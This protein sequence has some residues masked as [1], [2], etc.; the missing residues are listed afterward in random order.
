[1]TTTSGV[2]AA[3]LASALVLAGCTT[4]ECYGRFGP[5]AGSL[6]DVT[7][8][9]GER[10]G[11]T[12]LEPVV[13]PLDYDEAGEE[14]VNLLIVKGKG[15]RHFVEYW[16]DKGCEPSPDAFRYEDTEASSSCFGNEVRSTVARAGV[17]VV[18]V[19]GFCVWQPNAIWIDDWRK[20]D[21]TVRLLAE[22]LVT[23]NLGDSFGVLVRGTP[24][25]SPA[26]CT[27]N[28]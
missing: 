9:P 28:D 8:G 12:V 10:Y 2:S 19:G 6:E 17:R 20:A 16:R 24:V 13:C 23:W 26:W 1:M 25:P 3:L 4:S 11:C 14:V 5:V 27:A 18:D 22:E 15:T 21:R 7:T